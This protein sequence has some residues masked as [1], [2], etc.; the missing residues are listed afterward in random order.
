MGKRIFRST[1]QQKAFIKLFKF[2]INYVKPHSPSPLKVPRKKTNGKME[3]PQMIRKKTI[4]HVL[5]SGN[6][7]RNPVKKQL[8]FIP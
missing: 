3:R 2:S 5:I 6:F 7:H 1:S 4:K 8:L